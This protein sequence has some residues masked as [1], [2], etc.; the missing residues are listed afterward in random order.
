LKVSMLAWRLL[1]NRLLT[2]DN[3][4]RRHI[5]HHDAGL[6]VTGCGGVETA[7]HL[8]L[9]C[10]VFAPLWSLVRSWVG[11]SSADSLSIHDHFLQFVYSAGGSQERLFFVQLLCLCCIWVVWLERNNIIFKAK[12][13]SVLQMVEKVKVHSF[14][15]MKAYNVILV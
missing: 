7:Y 2:K 6:C 13:S 15:W 11:V 1:R 3:L 14:W 4:V 10:P 8:F 12:E 9:F 5:T